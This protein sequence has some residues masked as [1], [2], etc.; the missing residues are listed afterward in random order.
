MA[1]T[2][3][4]LVSDGPIRLNRGNELRRIDQSRLTSDAVTPYFGETVNLTP[5]LYEIGSKKKS[6][7]SSHFFIVDRYINDPNQFIAIVIPK[8]LKKRGQ[9]IAFI[10]LGIPINGGNTIMF[11][12]WYIDMNGN[13]TYESA[14]SKQAPHIMWS[15]NGA[16]LGGDDDYNRNGRE[17]L[18]T[19]THPLLNEDFNGISSIL[20]AKRSKKKAP[21]LGIP[22]QGLFEDKRD[23]ESDILF[24]GGRMII[25]QKYYDVVPVNG[26]GGA[27]VSFTVGAYNTMRQQAVDT[28]TISELGTFV[29]D[30]WDEPVL[31]HFLQLRELDPSQ[32]RKLTSSAGFRPGVFKVTY[33]EVSDF[34][35]LWQKIRELFDFD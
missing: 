30:F 28:D 29:L 9:G 6:G 8:D 27:L 2:E 18:L 23:G 22:E 35:T 10:M 13:L 3:T 25:G 11:V 19:G 15:R 4:D 32:T 17:Y 14:M 7:K 21:R 12:N 1:Q 20:G 26:E 5:G 31:L 34:R 33:N 16:M 24:T